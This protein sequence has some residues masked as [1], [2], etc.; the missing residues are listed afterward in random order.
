MGSAPP[1][2]WCWSADLLDFS[3]TAWSIGS[4]DGE[5]ILRGELMSFLAELWNFLRERRRLWMAPIIVV[6][7]LLGLLLVLSQVS[8]IAP[9]IYTIF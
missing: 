8:A 2:A 7:L 3:A 9:F 5:A 4:V 6:T 1:E